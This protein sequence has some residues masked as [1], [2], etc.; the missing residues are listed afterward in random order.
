MFFDR[1][2]RC[3]GMGDYMVD[4]L[5]MTRGLLPANPPQDVVSKIANFIPIAN[6]SLM[7]DSLR[8]AI[9]AS[10][11]N[12]VRKGEQPKWPDNF[13]ERVH[14]AYNR[15]I[16]EMSRLYPLFN[17]FESSYRS[18]VVQAFDGLY[19][20]DRWWKEAYDIEVLRSDPHHH[21]DPCI[22]A[23]GT[24]QLSLDVINAVHDFSRSIATN[25][26]AR[27]LVANGAA[28]RDV[29][30]YTKLSDLENLLVADWANIKGAFAVDSAFGAANFKEKF[31]I[32]RG[33]RNTVFHHRDVPDKA[34][35]FSLAE[36]LLDLV[37]VHLKTAYDDAALFSVSPNKYS[38]SER[39]D[40]HRYL[41]ID[42]K[43]FTV[44]ARFGEKETKTECDGTCSGEALV[45][46]IGSQKA[47][48]LV[49]LQWL[50]VEVLKAEVVI[51]S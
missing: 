45:R 23:I 22:A 36:E 14:K 40:H 17:L 20:S 9:G 1:G 6:H 48:R 27:A 5:A 11:L 2:S 15:R 26:E 32:V 42:R 24:K 34:D 33:A 50:H 38:K 7:M 3:T 12:K 43:G 8:D 31:S 19:N 51:T 10:R 44:T 16:A 29:V 28:T 25:K 39:A 13:I 21:S 37:G 46:Y 49:D 41:Q 30:E 4:Y 18:F 47:S 35:L